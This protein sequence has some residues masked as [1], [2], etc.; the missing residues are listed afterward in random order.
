MSLGRR[1]VGKNSTEGGRKA[2][3][4]QA[5]I[6][7]EKAVQFSSTQNLHRFGREI[8]ALV[9]AIDSRLGFRKKPVGPIGRF[10]QGSG[11]R[12]VRRGSRCCGSRLVAGGGTTRRR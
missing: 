4:E 1:L 11:I 3:R 6:E 12:G 10:G 8:V 2:K 7:L 5:D 9:Q